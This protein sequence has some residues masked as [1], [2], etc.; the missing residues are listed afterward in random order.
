VRSIL[1]SFRARWWARAYNL[2]DRW[3]AYNLTFRTPSGEIALADLL[4]FC[5]VAD[6][7]P[8]NGDSFMQGRAVGRRDVGLR[9]LEHLNLSYEELYAVIQG[10]SILKPADFERASNA[11]N[12]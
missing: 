6:E 1:D 2:P 8:Q 12:R 3:K 9:I 7:A 11:N 4:A 5:G 10:R